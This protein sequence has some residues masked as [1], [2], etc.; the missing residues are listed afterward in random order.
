MKYFHIYYDK[1]PYTNAYFYYSCRYNAYSRCHSTL[2]LG[3]HTVQKLPLM[4]HH[5]QQHLVRNETVPQLFW[6]Q[7]SGALWLLKFSCLLDEG[8]IFRSWTYRSPAS[9][10]PSD[11]VPKN[12]CFR[13]TSPVSLCLTKS[14]ARP[15]RPA[16]E[17]REPSFFFTSC[18]RAT[19]LRLA[20]FL[21]SRLV[22]VVN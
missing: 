14:T 3:V 4:H 13:F 17:N 15:R 22:P 10:P 19:H 12:C 11:M 18:S 1:I 5:R 16:R 2:V 21:R 20:S 9:Q 7:R 6:S 8:W